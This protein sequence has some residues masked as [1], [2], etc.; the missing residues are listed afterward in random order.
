[1]RSD[2][3][4]TTSP[5]TNW[6]VLVGLPDRP[7]SSSYMDRKDIEYLYSFD[8]DFDALSGITRLETPDNPFK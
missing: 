3:S 4:A 2:M 6:M 8:D 1:M 7:K 5:V